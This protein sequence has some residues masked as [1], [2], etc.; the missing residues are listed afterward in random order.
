[1]A[2]VNQTLLELGNFST[3]VINVTA[4]NIYLVFKLDPSEEIPLQLL[5]GFQDYPNDTNYEARIQLPQG[6]NSEGYY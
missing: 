1:M 5:L 6:G 3:V 2:E 4:P